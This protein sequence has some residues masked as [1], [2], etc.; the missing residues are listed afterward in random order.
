M[1]YL[2]NFNENIKNL[3]LDEFE[4][5]TKI[6]TTKLNIINSIYPDNTIVNDIYVNWVLDFKYTST[7]GITI[8]PKVKHIICDVNI[9]NNIEQYKLIYELG[10]DLKENITCDRIKNVHDIE[11]IYIPSE[12]EIDFKNKTAIV[13]F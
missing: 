1:R 9:E 11:S 8:T 12:I 7:L 5:N 6:E 10:D 13:Y 2:V 3:N 4:F